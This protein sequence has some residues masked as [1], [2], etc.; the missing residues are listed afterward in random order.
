[1]VTETGDRKTRE[2]QVVKAWR[3]GVGMVGEPR[4]TGPLA[5]SMDLMSGGALG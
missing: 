3:L 1:M 2:T 5:Q 4:R